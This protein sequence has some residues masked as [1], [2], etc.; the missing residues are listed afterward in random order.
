MP[1]LSIFGVYNPMFGQA[2]VTW[3][4][5]GNFVAQ[6]FGCFSGFQWFRID[7]LNGETSN[8][9]YNVSTLAHQNEEHMG[10]KW[11]NAVKLD[12][13]V[14]LSLTKCMRRH[15][16]FMIFIDLWYHLRPVFWSLVHFEAFGLLHSLQKR[17]CHR[18][19][20]VAGTGIYR[21]IEGNATGLGAL[22]RCSTGWHGLSRSQ[23]IGRLGK[24][25]SGI[26]S[27]CQI[28]IDWVC[29]KIGILLKSESTTQHLL[30][31]FG[32]SSLP[33]WMSPQTSLARCTVTLPIVHHAANASILGGIPS[34]WPLAVTG[35]QNFWRLNHSQKINVL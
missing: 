16:T 2:L 20:T 19:A 33:W 21:R 4:M 14:S 1:F 10:L 30:V 27:L 31:S 13:C 8:L 25:I 9:S 24:H 15:L 26:I 7:G 23:V 12:P 29:F 34:I 6:R 5:W 35:Q 22:L 18:P 32:G 11:V 17:Q 28:G 3:I